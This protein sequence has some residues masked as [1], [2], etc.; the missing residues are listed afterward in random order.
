MDRYSTRSVLVGAEAYAQTKKKDKCV[1]IPKEEDE[2]VLLFF[3]SVL[4]MINIHVQKYVIEEDRKVKRTRRPENLSTEWV[5]G[6]REDAWEAIKTVPLAKTMTGAEQT[7]VRQSR[8]NLRDE[9]N[10]DKSLFEALGM[11]RRTYMTRTRPASSSKSRSFINGTC[12][13][14]ITSF[15]VSGLVEAGASS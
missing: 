4:S 10:K 5:M 13:L 11:K 3:R 2:K 1:V 8:A 9:V 7:R 6:I 15:T 12:A 14:S